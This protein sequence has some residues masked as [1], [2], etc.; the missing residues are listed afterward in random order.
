MSDLKVSAVG[1]YFSS[2]ECSVMKVS[3]DFS[4]DAIYHLEDLF[5]SAK[6]LMFQKVHVQYTADYEVFIDKLSDAQATPRCVLDDDKKKINIFVTEFD[7]D[8][9]RHIIASALVRAQIHSSCDEFTQSF[10]DAFSQ[11]CWDQSSSCD[12][13]RHY[14]FVEKLIEKKADVLIDFIMLRGLLSDKDII[15]RLRN[16]AFRNKSIG[17]EVLLSMGMTL[18]EMQDTRKSVSKKSVSVFTLM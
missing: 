15:F 10:E 1:G 9:L 6:R 16:V 4:K 7:F 13:D 2:C 14:Q 3:D 5:E 18:E 12:S 17:E 11:R 8:L